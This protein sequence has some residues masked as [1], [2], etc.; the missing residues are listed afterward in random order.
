MSG[1]KFTILGAGAFGTAL[2]QLLSENGHDVTFYDP[3]LGSDL[4]E[5]IK[6]AEVL[7]LAAPSAAVP[8]LLPELP[9]DLPLVIATKGLLSDKIFADFTDYMVLSGP[10][11]AADIM[12]Q[13]PTLLTATDNRVAEWFGR[14]Y[15][16]L[17]F[18]SDRLGVLLCGALK[19][20]YAI[21]AGLLNLTPGT[22][23]HEQFLTEV[24]GEMQA[25]LSANGAE[26]ATVN[27]ACGHG[28]L[29]L[30]CAM[31]SRNYE[32]GQILRVNSSA[33]PEKTVE[34]AAA[35]A[36]IIRGEIEVPTE[37]VKLRELM[38]KGKNWN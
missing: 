27:L 29:R 25:L 11:F 31:P 30:T 34:G 8:S 38:G 6:D 19:N 13:R 22:P 18:T 32:F 9:H 14:P 33:T 16:Q 3:K 2:G 10:G 20:V 37:A 17:D 28:D 26:A 15:L 24:G 12:A 21:L 5:C 4:T 1:K 35:L 23:A 36:A 7:V